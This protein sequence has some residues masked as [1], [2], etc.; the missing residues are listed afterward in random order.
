MLRGLSAVNEEGYAYTLEKDFGKY[1]FV[2]LDGCPKTGA[3]R[4]FNFFGYLD[5]SDMD[6]LASVLVKSI[7]EKHNHTFGMSHYP[8]GTT[9]FGKTKSG[10]GFWDLSRHVSIWLCGHL[11][12]LAAGLGD[13]MYAFQE[14]TVLEL[15][16]GDMKSHGLFRIIAIDNDLV[17]FVDL[18]IYREDQ[19]KLPLLTNTTYKTP[20]SRPPIVLITNPKDGRYNI[21]GKEPTHLVASS[22]HI[23][24]L[25]WA[26]TSS[27]KE[28]YCIVDDKR[29]EGKA[30]YNGR[31]K[32]W[33]S[34]E[35][36]KEPEPYIPLWTIPWDPLLYNDSAV[37][38]LTVVATDSHGRIGNHTVRFRLDGER[39]RKMDAG[40]GGTL[41]YY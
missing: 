7:V 34:I 19:A 16:L 23:R 40:P 15:E 5:T 18:P 13:T 38:H 29:L 22:T 14:N 27:L 12:Q 11:H 33:S 32:S 36:I 1:S 20:S 37:H 2:A 10:I 39:I 3:G 6:F 31:G 8:T 9:L 35:S 28:I 26:S 17:S 25:I 4:P 30:T 24:V 21:P 41:F